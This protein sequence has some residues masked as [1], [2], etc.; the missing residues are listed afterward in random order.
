MYTILVK[1]TNELSTTVKERIM[2]RSKLIDNLHFQ[3]KSTSMRNESNVIPQH[4][5]NMVIDE[6]RK[7]L[8]C[9]LE[10]AALSQRIF[11]AWQCRVNT[12]SR[13]ISQKQRKATL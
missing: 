13:V 7:T 10:V 6:S 9:L 1:D 5:C 12:E 8:K 3:R 4:L 11:A 2:Q